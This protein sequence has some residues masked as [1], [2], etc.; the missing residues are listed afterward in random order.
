MDHAKLYWRVGVTERRLVYA[1][2]PGVDENKHPLMGLMETPQLA[3]EVVTAHNNSL[4]VVSFAEKEQLIKDLEKTREVLKE[5]E[6]MEEAIILAVGIN[7]GVRSKQVYAAIGT[8]ADI[9]G[10]KDPQKV[11]TH[12]IDMVRNQ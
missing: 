8:S 7:G 1:V 5:H 3:I 2:V 6:D 11:L 9:L 4:N 12:A 10:D